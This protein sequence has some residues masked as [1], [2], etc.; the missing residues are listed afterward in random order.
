MPT[1][2]SAPGRNIVA[3][4]VR[5]HLRLDV[6]EYDRLIR[7]FIPGYETMLSMA[8]KAVS[9]VHP[10][11]VL[12]LG[13]GT[14]ALSEALL[15]RDPD[16]RVELWD[17]DPEMLE[18]ARARLER[19]GRRAMP[20]RAS[21]FDPFPPCDAIMGS[22]SLHHIPSLEQKADLYRAAFGALRPGGVLVVAD[23]MMPASDDRRQANFERWADHLATGGIERGEAFQRFED[24][25][26]EDTYFPLCDE[27]SALERCG[28]SVDVP[29]RIVP[30]A[31]VVATKP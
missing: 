11:L 8:S 7:I 14:A 30:T 23:V 19:F 9:S 20:K 6:E 28:F 24:W 17:V 31:V 15:T 22:L 25:S 4:S 1:A 16:A 27:V 3:H 18:Q 29:W 5:N 21:Y 12:D 13:A 26:E 2:T 10:E